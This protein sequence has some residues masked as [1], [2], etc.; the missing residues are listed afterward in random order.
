MTYAK[1]LFLAELPTAPTA[2][3]D[4]GINQLEALFSEYEEYHHCFGGQ[5][6]A[7]TQEER[8]KNDFYHDFSFFIGCVYFDL[9]TVYTEE[10]RFCQYSYQ[11]R[12]SARYIP[13]TFLKQYYSLMTKEREN[14]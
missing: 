4:N 12:M 7:A 13:M 3:I 11:F 10:E 9:R 5:L 2:Q 14:R 8:D 6:P 1:Q